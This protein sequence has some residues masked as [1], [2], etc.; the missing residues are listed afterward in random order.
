MDARGSL[1]LPEVQRELRAS[2][3]PPGTD[4]SSS[5]IERNWGGCQLPA[6]ELEL[7]NSKP[8]ALHDS[9]DGLGA[10]TR[11]PCVPIFNAFRPHGCA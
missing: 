2:S 8:V 10:V 5:D 11:R 1:E 9:D 3:A 4:G 7:E 6:L